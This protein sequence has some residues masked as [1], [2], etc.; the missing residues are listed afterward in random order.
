MFRPISF[1]P[2]IFRG[3]DDTITGG[4]DTTAGGAGNDTIT[5]GND[6]AAGGGGGDTITGGND[7]TAGGGNDTLTAGEGAKWWEGASLK[8][9]REMLESKGLTVDDP[10]EAIAK[11]AK[12]EKAAQVKL[13]KPAD[14]LLSKPGKGENLADWMK[15]NAE[16][17][18]IPETADKYEIKRPDTWPKDAKWNEDLEGK[19]REIA[20]SHGG[21]NA[22][23][24]DMVGL[25]AESLMAMDQ[26][27][28][29]DLEKANGEMMTALEKDWGQ[30]TQA[31]MTLASQAASVIAEKAGLDE[32]AMLNLGEALKPKIGDAG[33]IRIFAAIG[34]MMGDDNL[35]MGDG[36]TSLS[37]TPAD[38]RAQLSAMQSPGGEYYEAVNKK[39]KATITRL[40]PQIERLTK[41]A[42]G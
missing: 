22:L 27:S 39:D 18:G 26:A 29:Q 23:V 20:H 1:W 31:K 34:E 17:F 42:S 32:T 6:T 24:N 19:A 41:I 33:T 11:L 36:G 8:E 5:G 40:K 7:T 2:V 15:A 4:D 3:P 9:H 30:E 13:G 16:V 14:Q 21:S 37:T 25:Y 28:A 12:M 38:A 35:V 10:V